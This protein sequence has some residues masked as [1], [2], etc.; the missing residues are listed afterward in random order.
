MHSLWLALASRMLEVVP[1]MGIGAGGG[2]AGATKEI[3]NYL[4]GDTHTREAVKRGEQGE[5]T[6]A[7]G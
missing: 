1:A 4:L 3:V 5:L 6:A 7:A 2:V